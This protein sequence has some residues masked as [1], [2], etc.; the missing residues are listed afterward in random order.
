MISVKSGLNQ[1]RSFWDGGIQSQRTFS[2]MAALVLEVIIS[3]LSKT[4]ILESTIGT[5]FNPLYAFR[6]FFST[7]LLTKHWSC[8]PW[9][10]SSFKCLLNHSLFF[11]KYIFMVLFLYS[12][13]SILI[14]RKLQKVSKK[15]GKR[16]IE[17]PSSLL[18]RV[19]RISSSFFIKFIPVFARSLKIYQ[20]LIY[21]YLESLSK[22]RKFFLSRKKIFKIFFSFWIVLALKKLA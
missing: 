1:F 2:Q 9:A 8:R 10:L 20:I 18:I 15:L 3:A 11:K 5:S 19:W 16:A 6:Y 13:Y 12:A 7:C 14:Q 22:F 17:P 21:Q 4:Q